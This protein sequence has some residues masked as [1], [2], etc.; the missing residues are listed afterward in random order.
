V[1]AEDRVHSMTNIITS[2][3]EEATANITTAAAA[4]EYKALTHISG[5]LRQANA[6]TTLQKLGIHLPAPPLPPSGVNLPHD[7]CPVPAQRLPLLRPLA[8]A[9]GPGGHASRIAELEEGESSNASGKAMRL[10]DSG[11]AASA[12][13]AHVAAA[14]DVVT[15]VVT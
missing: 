9:W 2:G 10:Q 7:L 6:P 11:V 5:L 1:L 12:A 4:T 3:T 15:Q 8:A 13:H 14:G